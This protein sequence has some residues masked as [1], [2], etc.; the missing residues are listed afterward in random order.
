M[1]SISGCLA[2]G[3]A[4]GIFVPVIQLARLPAADNSGIPVIRMG[5]WD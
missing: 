2:G 1:L 3:L 5:G 4:D